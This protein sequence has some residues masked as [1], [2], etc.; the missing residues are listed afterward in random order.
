MTTIFDEMM[1]DPEFRKQ[2]AVESFIGDTAEL[3]WQLLVQRNMNQADL[4]RLLNKTPAFVSQLLNGKAN[5]TVRTLAEV[6]YALGATVEINAHDES[7]SMGDAVDAPQMQTFRTQMPMRFS[8]KHFQWES[9]EFVQSD[10]PDFDNRP[11]VAA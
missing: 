4:A 8:G 9:S 5:M 2:Y 7:T 1:L 10:A 11:R 6:V 3:I